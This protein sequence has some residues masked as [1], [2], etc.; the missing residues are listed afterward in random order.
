M[1]TNLANIQETLAQCAGGA[2]P[3]QMEQLPEASIDVKGGSSAL[4]VEGLGVK[5]KKRDDLSITSST[6]AVGGVEEMFEDLIQQTNFNNPASI[7]SLRQGMSSRLSSTNLLPSSYN[8]DYFVDKKIEQGKTKVEEAQDDDSFAAVDTSFGATAGEEV[9]I[10][11]YEAQRQQTFAT[12]PAGIEDLDRTATQQQ[13]RDM[14]PLDKQ[15]ATSIFGA[16]ISPSVSAIKADPLA[17]GASF[18]ASKVA[19]AAPKVP[20]AFGMYNSI[21]FFQNAN[22]CDLCSIT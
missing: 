9:P 12:D 14:S 19:Q 20:T 22:F 3:V 2:K 17:F 8:T 1:A 7:E 4:D 11:E 16:L 21:I 5:K 15:M 10:E 18:L 6:A 13:Y